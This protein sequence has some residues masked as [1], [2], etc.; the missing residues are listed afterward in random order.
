MKTSTNTWEV[1]VQ[2]P[3]MSNLFQIYTYIESSDITI[4]IYQM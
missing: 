2:I 4:F 3:D 1:R